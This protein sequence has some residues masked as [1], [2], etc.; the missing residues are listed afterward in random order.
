M[1][2]TLWPEQMAQKSQ[3][4]SPMLVLESLAKC[5][6]I[7]LALSSILEGEPQILA[8][9][10]PGRALIWTPLRTNYFTCL[11]VSF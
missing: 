10:V 2:P 6:G 4:D 1:I 7:K 9:Q 11:P 5:I 8:V 3:S